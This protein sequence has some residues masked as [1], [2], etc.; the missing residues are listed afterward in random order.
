MTDLTPPTVSR[1]SLITDKAFAQGSESDVTT[2]L[3]SPSPAPR[4]VI[5]S[6]GG[7][8][9]LTGPSKVAFKG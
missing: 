5:S 9:L 4:L 3:A 1:A 2:R 6:E 7:S 8:A